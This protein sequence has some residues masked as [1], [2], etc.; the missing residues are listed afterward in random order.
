MSYGAKEMSAATNRD[1]L[2]GRPDK[3]TQKPFQFRTTTPKWRSL[4]SASTVE[5]TLPIIPK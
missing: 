4:E 1:D 5:H 3:T 2:R